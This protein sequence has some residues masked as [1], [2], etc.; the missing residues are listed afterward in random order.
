M[1][2]E[3]IA[4]VLAGQLSDGSNNDL[5]IGGA[6]IDE[7]DGGEGNNVVISG[8]TDLDINRDGEANIQDIEDLIGR[9]LF[10]DEHW[11]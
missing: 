1:S 5:V 4:A 2:E 8:G 9:D 10:E 11:V 3:D 6:G 7:V